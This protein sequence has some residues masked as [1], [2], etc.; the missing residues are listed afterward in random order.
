[1]KTKML[2]TSANLYE[3]ARIFIKKLAKIGGDSW[4]PILILLLLMPALLSGD[5]PDDAWEEPTSTMVAGEFFAEVEIRDDLLAVNEYMMRVLVHPASEPW[6]N[7]AIPQ[8]AEDADIRIKIKLR[9]VSV[10][11]VLASRVR[12]M[13][14]TRRETVRF[15]EAMQFVWHLVDATDSLI[16]SSP[17]V[18]LGAEMVMCD[19]YF[20]LAGVRLSLA[21][22]LVEAGHARYEPHDWGKRIV[23]G[24]R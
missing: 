16:L 8:I 22:V 23:Q 17:E 14:E 11:S 5:A 4:M 21:E 18:V 7:T 24:I 9:G 3:S 1:M 12:P 13:V 2:Q 15:D 20:E 19:V 6:P 10:P